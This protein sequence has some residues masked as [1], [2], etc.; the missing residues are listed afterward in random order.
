MIRAF[1]AIEIGPEVIGRISAAIDQLRPQI[2][3][4]RW[5]NDRNFHVTLRFLGDVEEGQ[6]EHIGA[7]LHEHI[8][9]FPRFSI[10]AKGLG[11]FPDLRRPTVLWVGLVATE[12]AS[13]VARLESPLERLGFAAEKRSFTPHLT[14]GRWRQTDRAGKSIGQTLE[15]W[16]D[17]QF[18]ASDVDEV[19]LFQ[20]VLKPEGAT[21][22]RLKTVKL[23]NDQPQ[24]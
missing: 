1:I 7:A 5:V 12:L 24:R 2:F 16:K 13:L 6:I 14:I 11:V 4:L 9:P 10:N 18:G 8:H 19:I 21:H 3:G 22:T 20:S 15:S 17:Y 23:K